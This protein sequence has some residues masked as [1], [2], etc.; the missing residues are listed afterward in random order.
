ML[1]FTSS[2]GLSAPGSLEPPASKPFSQIW[3][4]L[5]GTTIPRHHLLDLQMN[6]DRNRADGTTQRGM[7]SMDHHETRTIANLT[8]TGSPDRDTGVDCRTERNAMAKRPRR[9]GQFVA[10]HGL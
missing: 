3:S 6:T 5:P 2:M 7:E 1:C 10:G 8:I 4:P 9:L